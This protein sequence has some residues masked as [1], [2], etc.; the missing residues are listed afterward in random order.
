MMVSFSLPLNQSHFVFFSRTR[1]QKWH[2][3]S[4][5]LSIIPISSLT[6]T[7]AAQSLGV[8]AQNL[9]T[10]HQNWTWI[11]IIYPKMETSH[12]RESQGTVKTQW[13]WEDRW[14]Q[15]LAHAGLNWK[16]KPLAFNTLEITEGSTFIGWLGRN[17]RSCFFFNNIELCSLLSL[18][19]HESAAEQDVGM[20]FN[21]SC[22]HGPCSLFSS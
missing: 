5:L 18:L 15:T 13:C 16:I 4:Q 2:P 3:G 19:K 21:W 12:P 9:P 11:T 14:T 6:I 7:Q 20:P 1:L 22:V 17:G 8:L 10:A